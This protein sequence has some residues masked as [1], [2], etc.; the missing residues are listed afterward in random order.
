M[1]ILIVIGIL[2]KTLIDLLFGLTVVVFITLI[3]FVITF[4]IET[5][6]SCFFEIKQ[7]F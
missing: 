2:I 3:G 7:Q 1:K 5:L 6:K 4:I